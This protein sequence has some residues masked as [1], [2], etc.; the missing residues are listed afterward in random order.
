MSFC[1]KLANIFMFKFSNQQRNHQI[2]SKCTSFSPPR[3]T[4]SCIFFFEDLFTWNYV[5]DDFHTDWI[6]LQRNVFN[7]WK[8]FLHAYQN[9]TNLEAGLCFN[10]MCSCQATTSDFNLEV[11]YYR[12]NEPS[13]TYVSGSAGQNQVSRL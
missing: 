13:M 5:E 12:W 11:A 6:K 7:F 10:D 1:V 9:H 2:L 3:C 4:R 8:F